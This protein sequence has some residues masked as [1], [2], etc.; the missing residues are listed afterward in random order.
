MDDDHPVEMPGKARFD[1]QGGLG[2]ED[3]D[4][5]FVFEPAEDPFLFREDE[6]V[7]EPIEE[8]AGGGIRK[9]R[10]T[11]PGPIDR[12]VFAQDVPAEAGHD[13]FPGRPAGEHQF[14]GGF[15]GG[16]D[17]TTLFREKAGD[18]GFAASDPP[19]QGDAKNAI[20]F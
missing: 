16:V 15:V 8:T 12:P 18:D 5:A 20:S 10:R 11:Q 13:L 7:E 1:G 9:N 14:V 17:E 4:A 2:Y 6:R 19:G 3:P